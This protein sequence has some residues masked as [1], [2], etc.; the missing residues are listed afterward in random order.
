MT[1]PAA[2]D[3][4]RE[5][6]ARA[7]VG[8]LGDNELIALL[9]GT[10]V[11]ARPALVVAQDVLDT[12]GGVRGLLR[13][14]VDELRRVSGV[15]APRAARLL[16]AIE[17]GRRAM[18]AVPLDRPRLSNSRMLGL[19]LMP[20]YS[21]HREERFGIVMLDSKHRLLRSEIL[22]V[23]SLDSSIAHPREIFRAATVA[24]AAALA[25]FHNHPSGDPA[26]SQ[27]DVLLTHRLVAAGQVM[28]ID[29]VDH[30]ILGDGR[31]FSFRD[32]GILL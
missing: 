17:L 10:G 21:G 5:K 4:P 12:A 29:V 20:L 23:G 32:A 8:A 18:V 13:V 2:H 22:S 16:A 6:L 9:L 31:W 28:G 30:V 27:D 25:L 7:G 26:P 1:A 24:S 19:Y 3:R 15:G 11:R 14:G